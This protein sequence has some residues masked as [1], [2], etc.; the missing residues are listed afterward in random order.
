V[1]PSEK[2]GVVKSITSNKLALRLVGLLAERKRLDL[3]DL[4]YDLVLAFSDADSGIKRIVVKTA[5]PL[6]ESRKREI[7]QE[8]A[9]P[10]GGRVVGRFEVAK[11]LIGG[12][13]LKMSDKVLD[14]S[15]KGRVEDLRFTLSHSRN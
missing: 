14:A 13:W 10:L 6:P 9:G 7:E 8:L 12:M 2:V 11:E 15:L 1:K 4:I 5:F 3:V